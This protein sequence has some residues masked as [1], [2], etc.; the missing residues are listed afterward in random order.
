MHVMPTALFVLLWSSG[1][2][3]S[4]WGLNH[5]SP[6]V[7]LALRFTV[8]LVLLALLGR[9]P[10]G[11]LPERG[12]RARVAG[13][14]L[15]LVGGYSNAYFLAMDHGLTPG[16]LATVLGVQPIATLVLQER[17]F[18]LGRLAGL[19]LALA[20]LALVVADSLRQA[21]VSTA[22]VLWALVALAC[23]TTGAM[24]QKR[25]EQPPLRVLPL[26]CA[27]ALL[28][29][30]ALL[31][32]Q[33]LRFEP[34]PGLWVPVLWL[35]GVI[36]VAATVL[37]YRMLR[38]GNLVNVTSLFYLV[39]GGTALLDW[40]VLGNRMAPRSLAGL[41]LVVAGLLLV[42][43]LRGDGRGGAQGSPATPR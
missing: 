5:A 41:A 28:L 19:L 7:F 10:R 36:S 15:L 1:A 4:R 20:G 38:A 26:Q 25:I 21:S 11:W 42:F 6:F 22:G 16:A 12:T 14:G 27:V 24:A 43:R 37:L 18:P 31:P 39:P 9:G 29:S 2:I 17:R 8:A 3:F 23:I 32:A 40:L 30:L 13:T 33:P 35:G 34:G